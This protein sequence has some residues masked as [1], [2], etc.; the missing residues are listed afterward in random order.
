[1]TRFVTIILSIILASCSNS[2]GSND[3]IQDS[4]NSIQEHSPN[5]SI[6]NIRTNNKIKCVVSVRISEKLTA[7][8]LK[9]IAEKIKT[10]INPK[11]NYVYIAFLLPEM[12]DGNGAWASADFEPNLSIRFFGQSLEDEIQINKSVSKIKGDNIGIWSDPEIPGDVAYRI[13]K[14]EVNGLIIEVISTSDPKPSELTTSLK[15]VKKNGKTIF[16]DLDHTGQYY[17]LEKNG[18]LS[19]YDNEGFVITYK[20]L[21]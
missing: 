15:M 13:R 19:V 10:E 17:L 7:T 1:M 11:S 18:D 20:K 12:Q 6:I 4:N 3:S 5:Y 8:Q 9:S 16:K 2:P 14:D 21:R